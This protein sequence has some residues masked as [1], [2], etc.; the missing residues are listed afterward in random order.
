MPDNENTDTGDQQAQEATDDVEAQQ[1][2]ADAVQE[3]DDD[4]DESTLDPKA[5][6]ALDKVRREAANLRKRLKELQPAADKLKQ[7]ED[8]D[9]TETQ[10]L[11][12]QLAELQTKVVEYE[13]REV[14]TAAAA[15]VGLPASMAQFITATDLDEAKAQAKA[16]ADFGKA[17]QGADFKQGARPNAGQTVTGDDFIRR[18]AG[19]K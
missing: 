5:K 8:R 3:T 9:K 18:M 2:L 1:L 13:V 11:T 15:S 19:R 16:L 10:R 17:G 14:R 6:S 12:E 7:L 4:A